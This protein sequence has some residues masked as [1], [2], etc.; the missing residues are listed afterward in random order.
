[1]E[2]I[3]LL[4]TSGAITALLSFG[5]KKY[6]D[7]QLKLKEQSQMADLKVKADREVAIYKAK[8]EQESLR[9]NVKTSGVYEK[10]AK[11]ITEIYSQLS[12]LEDQMNIAIN[13]GT[14]WDEKY[15][16][17]KSTYFVLR[18]FWRRNRILLSEEVDTLIRALLSD[19]FWA[20][21]HYGSGESSFRQGNFDTAD[22]Q[23]EKASKLIESIPK[24]LEL[25][26]SEFRETIGVT[27]KNL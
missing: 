19:T 12:D 17:F 3:E 8:L 5:F 9:F 21:E 1:M 20:V 4:I 25:L 13:Q 11:V 7:H 15:Q 26:V 14:P 2:L 16:K 27:G 6:I 18:T 24:I 22:V 23:K 10:Q